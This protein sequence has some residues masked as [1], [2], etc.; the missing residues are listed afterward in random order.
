MRWF[1]FNENL[2]Q[3]KTQPD[4][5]FSSYM[6]TSTKSFQGIDED[7]AQQAKNKRN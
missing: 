5:E 4:P 3:L 7:K 2:K 6:K 1:K